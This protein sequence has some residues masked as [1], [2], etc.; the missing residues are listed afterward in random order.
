MPCILCRMNEAALRWV[1]EETWTFQRSFKLPKGFEQTHRLIWELVLD[2]VDTVA[3]VHLN[4]LPHR[5][6]AKRT[7]VL[8]EPSCIAVLCV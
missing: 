1:A 3:A 8:T 4:G 7:Q 2:G 5:R 6:L